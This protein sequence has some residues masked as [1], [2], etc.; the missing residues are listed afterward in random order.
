MEF[1]YDSEVIDEKLMNTLIHSL[2]NKYQK[3]MQPWGVEKIPISGSQDSAPPKGP[4]QELSEKFAKSTIQD[5]IDTP[6]N[7]PAAPLP[8]RKLQAAPIGYCKAL[9][10]YDPQEPDDLSLAKGDKIAVVEHL[11]PDWWKG[12]KQLAGPEGAG[13]FP[14]NY[15]AIM[16]EAEF[17]QSSRP[18][19]SPVP[20]KASYQPK[21]EERASPAAPPYDLVI[22][23]P[24]YN[25]YQGYLP[26]PPPAQPSYGPPAMQ[27]QPSYGGYAQFP[28]PSTNYY[29]QQQPAP[30]Q[31]QQQLSGGHEHL[32]K[33][34]SK[35]GNAA[36]FGAGATLGGDLVNS[37]F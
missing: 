11:S 14:S 1:L 21:S 9:Y 30:E 37:I 35:F 19:A 20:E 12:Y 6:A 5:K 24:T 10:N 8:A 18:A 26:Q 33:F 7:P 17:N 32:K 13:V 36:I 3:D 29:P 27:P 34:G 23:Q 22:P 2:P 31:Q 16:S 15:V 25:T 28:P 4:E